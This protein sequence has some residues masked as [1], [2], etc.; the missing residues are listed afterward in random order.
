MR[1]TTEALKTLKEARRHFLVKTQSDAIE[2]L[3]EFYLNNKP[4]TKKQF[5]KPSLEDYGT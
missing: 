5:K 4:A 2:F 1:L 3:A